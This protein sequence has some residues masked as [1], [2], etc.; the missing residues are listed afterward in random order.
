MDRRIVYPLS[1]PQDV[2]VLWPQ[3]HAMTALGFFMATLFGT[4][5]VATGFTATVSGL[6]VTVGAGSLTSYGAV[7]ATAFGSLPASSTNIQK[8]GIN[9]SGASFTITAPAVNV[10]QQYLIEAQYYESDGTPIVLPYYN[11]SNPSTPFSGPSNSGNALNTVRSQ[12]VNLQIIAGSSTT[13]GWQPLYIVTATN[14]AGTTTIGI[15]QAPS[16][17]FLPFTQPSLTPGFSRYQTWGASATWTVPTG[18]QL[19]KLRM[20]GGGGGG[21]GGSSSNAGGGGA[22]AYFEGIL[23][24]TPQ[25]VIAITIGGPGTGG[26]A[27]ASGSSGVASS[28][29]SFVT[30]GG[31]GPGLAS[32]VGGTGGAGGVVTLGS[33]YVGPSY[34]AITGT[35]GQAGTNYGACGG[36]PYGGS[37][38]YAVGLLFANSFGGGGGGS[39]GTFPGGTGGGGFAILEY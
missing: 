7:D 23:S 18:V 37:S 6:T 28:F 8:I 26:N 32:S 20:W 13:S 31:G 1:V 14:T 15:T 12:G 3:R 22:G 36:A 2:D 25:Q 17:P 11:A 9:S 29:G 35:A 19:G 24:F 33:G 39:S 16:S 27:G 10:T 38:S 5:P 34:L 4:A 30:C 21:G